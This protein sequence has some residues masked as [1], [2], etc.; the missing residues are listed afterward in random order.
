MYPSKCCD[1]T[2]KLILFDAVYCLKK[3]PRSYNRMKQGTVINNLQLLMAIRN[4]K[5]TLCFES[6]NHVWQGGGR[7]RWA[8]LIPLLF[9]NNF[10]QLQQRSKILRY[11]PSAGSDFWLQRKSAY[12]QGRWLTSLYIR[13]EVR[14][15]TQ[16]C[17]RHS[18]WDLNPFLCI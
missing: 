6:L 10:L 7:K 9:D 3:A 13:W 17:S 5:A 18:L 14:S 16:S 1:K 11:T 4:W 15:K 2:R 12:C 8:W